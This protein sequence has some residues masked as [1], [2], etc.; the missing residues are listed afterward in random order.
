[1]SKYFSLMLIAFYSVQAK[2]Q[3][4]IDDGTSGSL[5][6][7]G[8]AS[9]TLASVETVPANVAVYVDSTITIEGTYVNTAAEV[10]LTGS[11]YNSGTFT[12]TGDEVFVGSNTQIISG[13]FTGVNDFY[14][15]I[16][17]KDVGAVLKLGSVVE[18]DASG[19]V[20]LD[21]GVLQA[22][23]SNYIYVKNN[24]PAAI[25]NS[26]N[27]GDVDKLIEGEV[28]RSVA[29]GFSYDF[30]VGGTHVD[31]G[32]GDGLQFA[33]IKSNIGSGVIS[34]IFHD[35]T[36][37]GALD[38]IVICG[39]G[40]FQDVQYRVG[41]GS[42]E[43]T[44]PG[45]GITNYNITLNP[46]DYTDNAYTSYTIL[47][48]G[49]ATGRDKCDGVAKSLPV[50]HD[51]LTSFSLFEVAAST[52]TVLPVELVNFKASL[53]DQLSVLLEWQTAS[54]INNDY[55]AVERSGNGMNWV[56]LGK[57]K[58]AGN[59]SEVLRYTFKDQNPIGKAYYRLKQTDMDGQ[60]NYSSIRH[61]SIPYLEI[62]QLNIYPNPVFNQITV[63][64]AISGGEYFKIFNVL[65]DDVTHLTK[66]NLNNDAQLIIDVSNLNSGFYVIKLGDLV[67]RVCK[68]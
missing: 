48:D 50:E 7:V 39:T 24:D 57:V 53:T 47:K 33:S 20:S 62:N 25:L 16:V 11:M 51:S 23:S 34:A 10:Q 19:V 12:T 4:F 43:I 61:V 5:Y 2:A 29:Q 44:N 35:S 18:V 68:E 60:F 65:G 3:I 14:N 21:Q 30:P 42:W 28:R 41:N 32:G 52:V 58:G 27:N 6:I 26:G 9:G 1:M 13:S 54:E 56:T 49:A 37:V 40:D 66:A 22:V 8:T 64:G 55:F 38:N 63:E 59:S 45:G 46:A 67:R 15:V 36:G 31:A 17:K